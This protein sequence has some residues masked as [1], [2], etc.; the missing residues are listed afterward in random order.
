MKC[1]IPFSVAFKPDGTKYRNERAIDQR[2][3]VHD[4]NARIPAGAGQDV[5]WMRRGEARRGMW[6]TVVATLTLIVHAEIRQA[7]C[8]HVLLESHHLKANHPIQPS[9]NATE[10]CRQTTQRATAWANHSLRN[11]TN[12]RC[13]LPTYRE[14]AR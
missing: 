14:L 8:L 11:C 3:H 4:R 12:G 6:A 13:R 7:E 10:T 5:D 2:N 9:N 1:G